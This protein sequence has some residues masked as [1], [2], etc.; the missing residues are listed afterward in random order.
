M[1]DT[2]F[3]KGFQNSASRII[4]ILPFPISSLPH[5][6]SVLG[7][8]TD[9]GDT[10]GWSSRRIRKKGFYVGRRINKGK[11]KNDE[12]EPGGQKRK[13]SDR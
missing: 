11:E 8:G 13:E 5:P 2:K 3:R 4:L 9:V 12:T 7:N 1:D 6:S 10:K